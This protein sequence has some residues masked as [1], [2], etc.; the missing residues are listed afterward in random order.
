M[1]QTRAASHNLVP[2]DTH[3]LSRHEHLRERIALGVPFNEE[4]RDWADEL[5]TASETEAARLAGCYYVAPAPTR[6]DPT[7]GAQMLD[8]ERGWVDLE[9]LPEP[10]TWKVW[11]FLRLSGWRHS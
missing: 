11:R 6:T 10:W 8:P 9:P 4:E 7:R 5:L 2:T 3:G 1:E